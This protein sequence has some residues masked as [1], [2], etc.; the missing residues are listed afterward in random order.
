MRSL[1]TLLIAALALNIAAGTAV[2]SCLVESVAQHAE[3]ADLIAYGRL[4]GDRFEIR[5]VLK[6]SASGTITVR[7]G[8]EKGAVTSVDYMTIDGIDQT[9][10]LW[11]E[12]GEYVTNSCSGSHPDLPTAEERAF[13]GIGSV[14]SANGGSGGQAGGTGGAAA[15]VGMAL[16]LTAA[17]LAALAAIALMRNRV[18]PAR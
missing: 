11:L 15:S 13:F 8:P 9:L 12:D 16:L 1:I 14:D 3:R 2:A 17:G 4:N 18:E 7:L 5:G 10:Y 6:G